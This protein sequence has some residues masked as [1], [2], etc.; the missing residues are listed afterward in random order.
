MK[1]LIFYFFMCLLTGMGVHGVFDTV[2]I[3][4][5]I[6]GLG[7][8]IAAYFLKHTRKLFFLCL[9][10]ASV[11]LGVLLV[12]TSPAKTYSSIWSGLV[13]NY[14]NGTVT[15]E[16]IVDKSIRT[17]KVFGQ[18]RQS[19]VLRRLVLDESRKLPGKIVVLAQNLPDVHFGDHLS[20]RGSLRNPEPQRNPHGFDQKAYFL[21]QGIYAIFDVKSL[22]GFKQKETSQL[23][24]FIKNSILKRMKILSPVSQS[25]GSA[26]FLGERSALDSGLKRSST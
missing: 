13:K 14:N 12:S 15:I 3:I 18:K 2:P 10:I 16:G 1:H 17:T 19:F 8:L 23:F 22:D 4:A 25:V 5:I 6:L 9:I 26:I 21:T 20:M 24:Y 7:S 11:N